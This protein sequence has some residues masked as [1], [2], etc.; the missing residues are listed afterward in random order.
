MVG[1]WRAGSLLTGVS[2]PREDLTPLHWETYCGL[3]QPA[4][5][6]A[7]SASPSSAGFV[8]YFLGKPLSPQLDH[9]AQ[10]GL[11]FSKIFIHGRLALQAPLLF[12]EC[13][14]RCGGRCPMTFV[15]L[16]VVLWFFGSRCGRLFSRRLL[17]NGVA[18]F[19]AFHFPLRFAR[20]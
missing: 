11:V 20:F 18:G 9:S 17:C 1:I 15:R 12:K 10:P 19:H 13:L 8:R 14:V 6:I 4:L 5:I 16:Q 3:R 7:A 2:S